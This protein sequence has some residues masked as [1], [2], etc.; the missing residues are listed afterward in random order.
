MRA[1]LSL[2]GLNHLKTWRCE[3]LLYIF[4]LSCINTLTVSRIPP[5]GIPNTPLRNT[6]HLIC[7]RDGPFN[8]L[9][10]LVL[11]KGFYVAKALELRNQITDAAFR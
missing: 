3:S 9:L 1:Y 10:T 6:D 4:I 5:F 2:V 8:N 11:Q 7:Q